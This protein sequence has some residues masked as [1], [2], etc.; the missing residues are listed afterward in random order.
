MG[1][2]NGFATGLV[3]IL[4][5]LPRQE[6]EAA[7]RTVAASYFLSG[8]ESLN[9][10]ITRLTVFAGVMQQTAM[11]H[12]HQGETDTVENARARLREIRNG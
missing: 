3:M 11:H 7:L 1:D 9:E 5:S 8:S 6:A 2:D 10:G 4:N 12:A